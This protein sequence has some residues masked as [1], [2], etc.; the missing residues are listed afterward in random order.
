M[1]Q[2]DI[3]EGTIHRCV[4]GVLGGSGALRRVNTGVGIKEGTKHRC[5]VG[6][7]GRSGRH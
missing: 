2:G 5:V 3:K 1:G 6:V 4:V 7:L